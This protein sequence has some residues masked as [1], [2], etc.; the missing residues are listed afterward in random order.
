MSNDAIAAEFLGQSRLRLQHSLEKVSHC[1][2]QLDDQQV[3]WRPHP[4]H[5]SIGNIILHLCGN[6]G[7]WIV[8]GVGGAPDVRDRPRE[9]S[10]RGP[11]ARSELIERLAQTI[12]QADTALAA[13]PADRLL[14]PRRIQG[15][16][17]HMLSAIYDSV[18]HL[19]GHTQEIVF[20]TRLQLG[21]RYRFH[22]TPPPVE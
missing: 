10:E 17:E 21:E 9:F 16:D 11:I 5:N 2:A 4:G 22:W 12:A 15:F 19:Q 18:A 20:I 8:S 6:L 14:E 13:A 1:L 3:W 7:Q